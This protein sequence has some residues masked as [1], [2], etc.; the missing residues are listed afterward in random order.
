MNFLHK[1]MYSMKFFL[2]ILC[3][4]NSHLHAPRTKYRANCS[5]LKKHLFDTDSHPFS[6]PFKFDLTLTCRHLQS[7]VV[8]NAVFFFR[9]LNS[10]E[11]KSVIIHSVPAYQGCSFFFF[12]LR[13]K[14]V[15]VVKF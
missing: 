1:V 3:P 13:R 12:L 15:P 9:P 5:I 6:L 11:N 10:L 14:S 8:C 2:F 7:S 4:F